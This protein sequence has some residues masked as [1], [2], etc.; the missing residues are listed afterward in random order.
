MEGWGR[1]GVK[2]LTLTRGSGDPVDVPTYE[3]G[4]TVRRGKKRKEQVISL[5][6]ERSMAQHATSSTVLL[7]GRT[8]P[9]GEARSA[10]KPGGRSQGD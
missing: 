10:S 5:S 2:H 7:H 3:Y 4:S 1:R 8:K 6:F 9:Q